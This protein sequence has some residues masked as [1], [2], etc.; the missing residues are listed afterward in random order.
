MTNDI[1][2]CSESAMGDQ[3]LVQNGEKTAA[4][5]PPITFVPTIVI[6]N[7]SILTFCFNLFI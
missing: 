5:K 7:V 6:N 3:L 4:L 1:T 2:A